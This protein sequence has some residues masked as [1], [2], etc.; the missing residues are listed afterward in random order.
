M[1]CAGN[2]V[3]KTIAGGY[4]TSVHLTG[5]YP[6]WW[7]GRRF[8]CPIDAWVAGQKKDTTR[9][10]VQY[11]LLGKWDD[12]GT[13]LIP[14]EAIIDWTRK[15]GTPE[16]VDIVRVKHVSGGISTVGFKAYAEGAGAF[17]GTAKHLVWFDE[18]CT[19]RVYTEALLR[20]A[21]VPGCIEG[22]IVLLTFTPLLGWSEV[23]DSFLRS[24]DPVI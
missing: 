8:D 6:E 14:G 24:G 17:Q 19:L 2:R 20:T 22:G 9:D 11:E 5:Q 21:I 3:G 12:F 23:V 18:E 7:E 4:E 13:G 16:A 15:D 1:F 10:I